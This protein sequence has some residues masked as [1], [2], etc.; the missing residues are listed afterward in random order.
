MAKHVQM[1]K[2]IAVFAE[3]TMNT[4]KYSELHSQLIHQHFLY[5]TLWMFES[6]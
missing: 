2:E 6:V 1:L 3:Y 5:S 4:L